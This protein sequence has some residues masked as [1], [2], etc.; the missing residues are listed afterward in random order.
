ML[1]SLIR[2]SISIDRLRV[3]LGLALVMIAVAAN[4]YMGSIQEVS[5]EPVAEASFAA[6]SSAENATTSPT[7]EKSLAIMQETEAALTEALERHEDKVTK[8]RRYFSS[9]SAPL[10][11][12]AET[13]V[14]AAENNGLDWRLLP[15]ISIVE[16]SGGIH[17]PAGSFN[18]WGW[19]VFTGRK[20][21]AAWGSWEESIQ[22]IAKGIRDG[23]KRRGLK[24]PAQMNARYAADT[25]W[26]FKVDREMAKLS[27]F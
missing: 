9:R 11:V 5:A 3:G 22:A 13:F 6:H 10:A 21:G 7:Q 20:S 12:Y 8:V 17:I 2:L 1:F 14:T 4:Y 19:A 26:G 18:A 23:Y 24:T 27:P 16:S 15:A 25:N